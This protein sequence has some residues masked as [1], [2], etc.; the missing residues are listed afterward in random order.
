MFIA[1]HHIRELFTHMKRPLF[2]FENVEEGFMYPR[3]LHSEG[4]IRDRDGIS[5]LETYDLWRI[6]LPYKRMFYRLWSDQDEPAWA[7]FAIFNAW[8]TPLGER[9]GIPIT[10]RRVVRLIPDYI[11]SSF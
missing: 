9:Y 8:P 2:V 11:T 7:D 6:P 1:Y 4:E 5:V 10:G 3:A